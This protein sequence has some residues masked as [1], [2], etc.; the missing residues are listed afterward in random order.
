VYFQASYENYLSA[1]NSFGAAHADA[2]W[3]RWKTVVIN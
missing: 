1:L 2:Q 3:A